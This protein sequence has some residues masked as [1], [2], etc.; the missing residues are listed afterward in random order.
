MNDE[1][2]E[3]LKE[4]NGGDMILTITMVGIFGVIVGGVTVNAIKNRQEVSQP[5]IVQAPVADKQQEV[6]KQITNLDLLVT[7]CSNEYI[8]KHDDL[9]CREMYCRVMTRGVDSKT[10][11]QECES[12]SNVANSQT[13]IK[14]CETFLEETEECYEKYRERK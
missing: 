4:W 9:L 5:V 12:I 8:E 10:S 14:H 6:I 11:G 13:I 3:N 7:P 2:Q 1:Q